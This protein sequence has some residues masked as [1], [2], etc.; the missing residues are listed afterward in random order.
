MNNE[1]Y[2]AIYQK[3]LS[4]TATPAE[5]RRIH[6]YQD[7]FRLRQEAPGT[8][9]ADQ[10]LENRLLARIRASAGIKDLNSP[11]LLR[12]PAWL[13]PAAAAAVLLAVPAIF[14]FRNTK[15]HSFTPTLPPIA[16]HPR[17][18][19]PGGNK[20]ILTLSSGRQIIRRTPPRAACAGRW[21]ASLQWCA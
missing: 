10:D 20:A 19:P 9:T 8:S 18:I 2:L 3:F 13:R 14:L 6:E 4:G 11:R 21:P 17:D 12:F 5:I 16:A 15:S 7:N 1:E